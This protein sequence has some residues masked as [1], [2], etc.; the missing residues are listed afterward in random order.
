MCSQAFVCSVIE[1]VEIKQARKFSLINRMM[2]YLSFSANIKI[3][4]FVRELQ[5][6]RSEEVNCSWLNMGDQII[7][8]ITVGNIRIIDVLNF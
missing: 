5:N 8:Y 6:G 2:Y 3:L 1:H 4:T 7:R